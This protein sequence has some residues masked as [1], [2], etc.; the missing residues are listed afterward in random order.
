MLHRSLEHR[1]AV[2]L[3]P[4]YRESYQT[5]A[6]VSMGSAALRFD[7]EGRVLWDQMWGSFCALAMAGGPPHKGRLLQ[8][9]SREQVEAEPVRYVEVTAEIVR[10]VGLATGIVAV[11]STF[12]WVR[13]QCANDTMAEWMLRAIVME[14]VSARGVGSQLELPAGP[15]YRLEKEIKNVITVVAKTA[16]YWQDHMPRAEQFAVAR[17]LDEMDA[18]QRLVTPSDSAFAEDDPLRGR[19][20]DEVFRAVGLRAGGVRYGGWIGFECGS[21]DEAIATMRLVVVSNVLARREETVLYVPLNPTLDPNGASVVEAIR[22]A[23]LF[24]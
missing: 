18:E 15:G 22:R 12:G 9:A 10:G 2:L 17:V 5:I 14:N 8:P 20:A 11:P 4:V 13:L 16:H 7:A 3:P 19:I 1:L 6:P 24:L 21:V 23:R